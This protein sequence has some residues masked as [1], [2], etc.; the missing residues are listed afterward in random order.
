MQ[1]NVRHGSC[2]SHLSTKHAA[3]SNNYI[4]TDLNSQEEFDSHYDD[5]WLW[6]IDVRAWVDVWWPVGEEKPE[7]NCQFLYYCLWQYLSSCID[8]P[9]S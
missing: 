5:F 9:L 6:I 8:R 3:I 2:N 7:P 1:K 4:M